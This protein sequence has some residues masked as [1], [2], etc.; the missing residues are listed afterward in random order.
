MDCI[1][2]G[3][4]MVHLFLQTQPQYRLT[5]KKLQYLLS[6]AQLV[7]LSKGRPLFEDEMRNLKNDFV[8]EPIADTFFYN[9]DILAGKVMD[10][11]IDCSREELV[12]PYNTKKIYEFKEFVSFDDKQ[13]LMDVFIRFGA[14]KEETLRKELNMLAPLRQLPILS[15]VPNDTVSV[16]L[17]TALSAPNF[18]PDSLIISACREI[19]MS[20]E[21][22]LATE[23][24]SGTTGESAEDTVEVESTP[25]HSLEPSVADTTPVSPEPDGG[26]FPDS[27]EFASNL[28]TVSS[29][30]L[31]QYASRHLNKL[32]VDKRY[33]LYVETPISGKVPAVQ[34]LSVRDNS[35]V[36]GDLARVT[37]TVYC[38]TFCG[39]ASDVKIVL[40]IH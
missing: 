30:V 37:D 29:N 36:P 8:L 23:P 15:Y 14:Y 6:V 18:L 17:T 34:V 27:S 16:F 11:A 12:I 35:T 7:S 3:K 10:R 26:A 32:I 5:N 19:R 1:T 4:V 22:F 20:D 40:D 24:V 31:K 2:A 25:V 9:R 38:F 13:V 21:P 28:P 39:V 33:S